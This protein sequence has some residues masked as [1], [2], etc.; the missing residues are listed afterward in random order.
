ME[1]MGT[2]CTCSNAKSNFFASRSNPSGLRSRFRTSARPSRPSPCS[3]ECQPFFN[4]RQTGTLLIATFSSVAQLP[5]P[6]ASV[7]L[8]LEEITPSV[9]SSPPKLSKHEKKVVDIFAGTNPSV[10]N[11]YDVSIKGRPVA[12][13]GLALE[14]EGNG[15]GFVIDE[16]NHIVTNYHVLQNILDGKSGVEVGR[17]A[18]VAVVY[19]LQPDGTQRM[20]DGLL[21]GVD[22][23]RDLAVLQVDS[24][25]GSLKPLPLGS[26]AALRIGEPVIAIGNPFGFEHTL[27]TGIV[28]ALGRGFSSQTGS[29]IGGGIQTD[30]ALNPGNSGGPLLN[31]NGQVV[32]VNSAI[33]TNTGQNT[34]IGFA[35]PVETVQRVVPQLIK[36]GKV[37]RANLGL[38]PAPDPV[39]RSLN[40]SEGVLIQTIDPDGPAAKAG[41]QA[42]RRG[43]TGIMTGDVIVGLKSRKIKNAYDL[44][45]VLDTCEVDERVEI[46]AIRDGQLIKVNAV[47][48]AD[49]T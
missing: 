39:T 40:V 25:S 28:S 7:A 12:S 3:V 49:G 42:T 10:V 22:R 43:L 5:S 20:C 18:K 14:P 15:S 29:V 47:L 2:E 46:T 24:S 35:I 16:N 38:T 4:R 21:V 30:A 13:T 44:S 45:T 26:S 23:E 1:Q 9:D 41:L 48:R 6:E 19:V 31:L 8:S 33:F 34:G 27:T 37:Q 11:V 36:F 32:G 17:K